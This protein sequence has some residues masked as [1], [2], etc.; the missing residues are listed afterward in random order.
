MVLVEKGEEL[1]ILKFLCFCSRGQLC[2][3]IADDLFQVLTFVTVALLNLKLAIVM[4]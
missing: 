3:V 4:L 1:N 2:F